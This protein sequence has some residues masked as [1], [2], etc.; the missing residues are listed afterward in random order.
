MY[1]GVFVWSHS[2]VPWID[3]FAI[4]HRSKVSHFAKPVA[5]KHRKFNP[6]RYA[7]IN[8][9]IQK[10]LEVGFVRESHIPTWVANVVLVKEPNGKWKVC[11]NFTNLNKLCL[12]ESFPIPRIDQLADST[13][14]H[15]LLS[16]MDAYS[17]NNQIRMCL[18]GEDKTTFTID[19]GLYYYTVMLFG[20][21]N[22]GVTYQ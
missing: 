14:N 4:V 20:L 12:K 16:F 7:I 11:I 9:E 18:E 13:T 10:P 17:R 1:K 22:V 15:E 2:D 21:K 6:Y 3:P 5:Q 19:Q 8:E